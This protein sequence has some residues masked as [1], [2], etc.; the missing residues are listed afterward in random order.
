MNNNKL[1]QEIF[2]ISLEVINPFSPVVVKSIHYNAIVKGL[3]THQ[4]TL[5]EVDRENNIFFEVNKDIK[6]G[7]EIPLNLLEESIYNKFE[8]D[9]DGHSKEKEKDKEGKGDK[10]KDNEGKDGRQIEIEGGVNKLLKFLDKN[11]ILNLPNNISELEIEVEGGRKGLSRLLKNENFNNLLDKFGL[12]TDNKLKRKLRGDEF[13]V[14][15]KITLPNGSTISLKLEA[16]E[17]EFELSLEIERIDPNNENRFSFLFNEKGLPIKF[18]DSLDILDVNYEYNRQGNLESIVVPETYAVDFTYEDSNLVSAIDSNGDV[19]FSADYENGKLLSVANPSLSIDYDYSETTGDLKNI[20]FNLNDTLSY[21]LCPEAVTDLLNIPDGS[22]E[23][24]ENVIDPI[25]ISIDNPIDIL[26]DSPYLNINITG[27]FLAVL[28]GGVV[29]TGTDKV[30]R[31]YGY[32]GSGVG[33]PGVSLS[34]L[35][36]VLENT[37]VSPGIYYGTSATSGIGA[38]ARSQQIVPPFGG[39][40][41]AVEAGFAFPGGFGLSATFYTV[42]LPVD[43]EPPNLLGPLNFPSGLELASNLDNLSIPFVWTTASY[44][45]SQ[46]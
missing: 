17:G 1:L 19:L 46:K 25:D 11:D 43:V 7:A 42:A 5:V 45:N 13:E 18:D 30:F 12:P 31:G 32:A 37:G 6:I 14:E 28:T 15:R 29:L 20:T 2:N 26:G 16:E 38:I 41:L 23:N 36:P 9:D 40:D 35:Y 21:D 27:G 4:N 33:S 8:R 22:F 24:F 3:L 39:D 10:E 44:T 34:T